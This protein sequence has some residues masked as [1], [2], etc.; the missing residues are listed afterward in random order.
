MK[1]SFKII[2]WI[3][4]LGS[5]VIL[6][7]SFGKD[8]NFAAFTVGTI[9]GIT[10]LG[11]FYFGYLEE[12]WAW[13]GSRKTFGYLT[14]SNEAQQELFVRDGDPKMKLY[15]KDGNSSYLCLTPRIIKKSEE[16]VLEGYDIAKI[17]DSKISSEIIYELRLR[18]SLWIKNYTYDVESHVR[19]LNQKK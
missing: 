14:D 3:L 12:E 8:F 9:F 15:I 10:G 6:M 7:F 19:W 2:G 16:Y 1:N 13:N 4:L 11:L 17:E 18:D 5:T